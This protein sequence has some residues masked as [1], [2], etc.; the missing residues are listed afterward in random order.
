M[1]HFHTTYT[2]GALTIRDYFEFAA[3]T[4]TESLVFL[5][6]IRATPA[7]NVDAFVSGVRQI[8]DTTG[9]KAAIGFEARLLPG[10]TRDRPC[11]GTI[12]WRDAARGAKSGH[13]RREEFSVQPRE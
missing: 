1:F 5:E 3:R 8:R 13:F 4:N 7:Y 12:L 9:M 11:A 10:G 2:D 6:H